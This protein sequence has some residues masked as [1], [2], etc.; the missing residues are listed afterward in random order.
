MSKTEPYKLFRLYND[1]TGIDTLKLFAGGRLDFKDGHVSEVSSLINIYQTPV[2]YVDN[3]ILRENIIPRINYSN[4]AFFYHM[5]ICKALKL[6]GNEI[7]FAEKN[8]PGALKNGLFVLIV[9]MIIAFY[10]LV[11]SANISFSKDLITSN[12][13]KFLN[14]IGYSLVIQF[15]AIHLISL[16]LTL[17][18]TFVMAIFIQQFISETGK[19]EIQEILFN[20]LGLMQIQFFYNCITLPLYY[21]LP[22][23]FQT[24][25]NF[26]TG[27]SFFALGLLTLPEDDDKFYKLVYFFSPVNSIMYS[28]WFQ[29]KTDNRGFKV[30]KYFTED[31]KATKPIT[32]FFIQ[33]FVTLLLLCISFL[34]FRLEGGILSSVY[35]LFNNISKKLYNLIFRKKK[36]D[37]EVNSKKVVRTTK[38]QG[39]NY[40]MQQ[41]RNVDTTREKLVI[42]NLSKSYSTF[43]DKVKV[44]KGINLTL[45][46]GEKVALLGHNGCGKTTFLDSLIGLLKRT[47]G[48]VFLDGSRINNTSDLQMKLGYCPQFTKTIP[49]LNVIENL[50][51]VS[52]LYGVSA[53]ETESILHDLELFDHR[54][55]R[56]DELS[57]G[58]KRKLGF[59]MAAIS[60]APLIVLDEPTTGI[61]V[62]SRKVIFNILRK[63]S[64]DSI[65]IFSTH[66]IEEAENYADKVAIL[67][68][69]NLMAFDTV[70][71]IKRKFNI[72]YNRL[73]INFLDVVNNKFIK[74][75]KEDFNLVLL[76]QFNKTVSLE[77]KE[78]NYENLAR[79]Y[80]VM[81]ENRHTFRVESYGVYKATLEEVLNLQE[82]RELKTETDIT[83]AEGSK[84][85]MLQVPTKNAV[86]QS[87]PFSTIKALLYHTLIN[88]LI[89]YKSMLTLI[90]V[91]TSM[92][93]LF[94]RSRVIA[95]SDPKKSFPN[96]SFKTIPFNAKAFQLAGNRKAKIITFDIQKPRYVALVEY[97]KNDSSLK[98]KLTITEIPDEK[99]QKIYD[100]INPHTTE[101]DIWE[102]SRKI[103]RLAA[104]K[105]N[106][107]FVAEITHELF[108]EVFHVRIPDENKDTHSMGDSEKSIYEAILKKKNQKK[109][110][111]VIQ[112]NNND[113]FPVLF[114]FL[115]TEYQIKLI[116]GSSNKVKQ[117]MII[118]KDF[119]NR[120]EELKTSSLLTFFMIIV[121]VFVTGIICDKIVDD[122]ES[123][124]HTLWEINGIPKLVI[125]VFNITIYTAIV[126]I[127]VALPILLANIGS[128]KALSSFLLGPYLTYLLLCI[129]MFAVMFSL[130]SYLLNKAAISSI[131]NG[132]ISI[133]FGLLYSKEILSLFLKTKQV[134][135]Y[136]LW[137]PFYLFYDVIGAMMRGEIDILT[138]EFYYFYKMGFP[139]KLFFGNFGM[140]NFIQT[141]FMPLITIETLI[142]AICA[143]LAVFRVLALANEWLKRKEYKNVK[144]KSNVDNINLK[145]KF[146]DDDNNADKRVMLQSVTKVYGHK[147]MF[148]TNYALQNFNLKACSGES[149]G[150]LGANGGGKTTAFKLLTKEVEATFGDISVDNKRLANIKKGYMG[151]VPQYEALPCNMTPYQVLRFYAILYNWKGQ[152]TEDYIHN[153][154][155]LMKLKKNKYK[156]IGNLSGGNKRKVVLAISI[157][158]DKDLLILDEPTTGVDITNCQDIWNVV[159]EKAVD[160]KI[161]LASHSTRESEQLTTKIIILIAGQIVACGTK[162]SIREAHGKNYEVEVEMH[163]NDPDLEEKQKNLK[164]IIDTAFRRV[165]YDVKNNF[166]FSCFIEKQLINISKLIGVFANWSVQFGIKEFF[167]NES[168]L[169]DILREKLAEKV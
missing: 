39:Q 12:T 120:N 62:L 1:Q 14:I 126:F 119:I 144:A 116:P 84:P 145:M 87:T 143:I 108:K 64:K 124:I 49:S 56:A 107:L 65:V 109:I 34:I 111:V 20:V 162:E 6:R 132:L 2:Y 16:V 89:D 98:D 166:K 165:K 96:S 106:D 53:S 123:G 61:D 36:T 13:T 55:K 158:L 30:L 24:I 19:L 15:I 43:G 41:T 11:V 27:I 169:E 59:A 88:L 83:I 129:L 147:F 159:Q 135:F 136:F 138:R 91:A 76:S 82:F 133:T 105:D 100:T 161:L 103:R 97:M 153:T 71:N 101:P 81:E 121:V 26:F 32:V 48:E 148:N 57:G 90:F 157:L 23:F 85:Q 78:T 37:E 114:N 35:M 68:Q 115:F 52:G 122:K 141:H 134:Q 54:L 33:V 104:S 118:N 150:V 47:T 152:K 5:F 139:K 94:H 142:F 3:N 7:F 51:L 151:Y 25:A 67:S 155:D 164:D 128:Y 70:T 156:K 102:I 93:I 163:E 38:V 9:C 99:V 44:L 40:N 160:K 21:L 131:K 127:A 167:I 42:E 113:S 130:L 60:S 69:G 22:G 75:L 45:H 8:S 140:S 29:A 31:F 95:E 92:C 58:Q 17:P 79:L 73:R 80:S 86:K 168:T 66:L 146:G 137:N 4:T 10:G 63:Y 46:K 110:L 112:K 149:I 74:H 77:I 50:Y 18:F 125:F 117:E 28:L 154:L 72:V